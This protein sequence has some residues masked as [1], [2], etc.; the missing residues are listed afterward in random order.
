MDYSLACV[1]DMRSFEW[2]TRDVSI[3]VN[4]TKRRK[5]HY[6]LCHILQANVSQ[7][8]QNS[9][10]LLIVELENM[11]YLQENKSSSS[12]CFNRRNWQYLLYCY[13]PIWN[14]CT[15]IEFEFII[16]H[17]ISILDQYFWSFDCRHQSVMCVCLSVV[18]LSQ[19]F[20]T[21]CF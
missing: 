20:F 15:I 1:S 2:T 3:T 8:V 11:N 10:T 9:S 16:R 4:E 14:C 5:P 12:D 21:F 18:S 19:K 17:F 13:T 6:F 7:T